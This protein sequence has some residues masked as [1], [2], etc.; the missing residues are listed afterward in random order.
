[1]IGQKAFG[2]S[3]D[4]LFGLGMTTMVDTLKYLGQWPRL[5]HILAMLMILERQSSFLRMSFQWCYISLSGPGADVLIHLLVADLN[6]YLEK[7]FQLWR[8]LCTTSLKMLRSTWQWSAVLN[9]LWKAF[10]KLSGVRQGWLLC[11][12]ASVTGSFLFLTQFI[13]FQG[14]RLLFVISWICRQRKI[15]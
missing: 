8:G 15:A 12:I 7:E 9:E 13:N 10:H 4:D 6:L 14:P 11:L 5:I 2:L 1:M 3:Y